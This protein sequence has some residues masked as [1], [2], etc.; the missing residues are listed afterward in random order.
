LVPEG[1]GGH[2]IDLFFGGEEAKGFNLF[3]KGADCYFIRLTDGGLGRDG[4]DVLLQLVD[5]SHAF[6]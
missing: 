5:L 3:I 1:L 4:D 2:G 6:L